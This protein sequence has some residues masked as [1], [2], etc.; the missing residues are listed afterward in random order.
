MLHDDLS[1]HNFHHAR[2]G[3]HVQLHVLVQIENDH[4]AHAQIKYRLYQQKPPHG[5]DHSPVHVR[6][7]TGPI[8]LDSIVQAY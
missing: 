1:D 5:S 8:I 3:Q 7:W 6:V 2:G 4:Q